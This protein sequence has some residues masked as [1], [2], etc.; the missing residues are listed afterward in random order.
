M[1]TKMVARVINGVTL[2]VRKI[3]KK[4]T[5]TVRRVGDSLKVR[6]VQKDH[7]LH[8]PSVRQEV[9][10]PC[11]S[12]IFVF[13]NADSLWLKS[14]LVTQRFLGSSKQSLFLFATFYQ[15]IV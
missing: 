8:F 4:T 5:N 3:S 10:L 11:Y 2:D 14:S 13:T 9:I 12:R 15:I 7:Y 6:I 1:A